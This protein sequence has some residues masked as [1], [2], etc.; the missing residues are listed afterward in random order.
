MP[1]KT[2][3]DPSPPSLTFPR[4]TFAALSPRPYLLAHLQPASPSTPLRRPNGRRLDETRAPTLHTNSLSHAHGSAVVRVGDTAVVCGVRGELLH[5]RDVSGYRLR[6]GHNP[7]EELGLLVPNVELAT[8]CN[9]AHLPGSPP[10]ALAQS[11][12]IRLLSLLHTTRLIPATALEIWNTPPAED[13]EEW[14]SP[15]PQL[16]AFWTLYID[17]VFISLAGNPF[18]AAWGAVLAAL[19]ATKLPHTWWSPDDEEVLCSPLASET[20]SLGLTSMPIACTFVA[21]TTVPP[22]QPISQSAKGETSSWVLVD[23]DTFEEG[24][25]K[26]SITLV[27]DCSSQGTGKARILRLEKS[28]GA[29]VGKAEMVD[30]VS[31]AA[32]RWSEWWDVLKSIQA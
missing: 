9:P 1:S 11:L 20:T 18:D 21:I 4:A 14:E 28:G 30:L 25:C 12:S 27:V 6:D 24:Q 2:A 3:V 16:K 19:S 31:R 32:A 5:L 17:L 22:G 15:E 10:S 26:E 13:R 7:I 23:P 29:C 8:G